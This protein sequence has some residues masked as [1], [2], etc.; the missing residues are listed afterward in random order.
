MSCNPPS[1]S[2]TA[3]TNDSL[4]LIPWDRYIWFSGKLWLFIFTI[5]VVGLLAQNAQVMALQRET[6][7][8]VALLAYFGVCRLGKQ[9]EFVSAES[10]DCPFGQ[11]AMVDLWHQPQLD[12]NNRYGHDRHCWLLHD[13]PSGPNLSCRITD[14]QLFKPQ[15]KDEKTSPAAAD[16][17]GD[18]EIRMGLLSDTPGTS[19]TAARAPEEPEDK[20]T[21]R[22]CA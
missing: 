5:I 4:A 1:L 13:R 10:A 20:P 12:R 8:F 3:G 6:G 21:A 7:T 22:T 16:D 9:E 14:A 11:P 19:E 17:Q 2:H 18:F 15:G